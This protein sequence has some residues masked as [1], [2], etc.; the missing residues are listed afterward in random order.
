MFNRVN[1]YPAELMLFQGTGRGET[2]ETR[3]LDCRSTISLTSSQ[4]RIRGIREKGNDLSFIMKNVIDNPVKLGKNRKIV[5]SEVHYLQTKVMTIAPEHLAASV[6]AFKILSLTFLTLICC[7]TFLL[8]NARKE[9][10][11]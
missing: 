6:T 3:L 10:T 11:L 9:K 5:S 4:T 8:P 2:L 7:S 1:P